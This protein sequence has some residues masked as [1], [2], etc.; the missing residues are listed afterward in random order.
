MS[1]ADKC[2]NVLSIM[3]QQ[4]SLKK[5]RLSIKRSAELFFQTSER[6]FAC[7]F[8]S[9]KMFDPEV[10]DFL[11]GCCHLCLRLKIKGPS[12]PVSSSAFAVSIDLEA[13]S[14]PCSQ[15]SRQRACQ[16]S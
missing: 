14:P 1:W 7:C 6:Y 12:L 8:V 2:E 4:K 11:R 10:Q 16:L 5:V 9:D 13:I 15:T 3:C